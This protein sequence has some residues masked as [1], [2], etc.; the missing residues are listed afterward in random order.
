VL[1]DPPRNR[2]FLSRSRRSARSL[3]IED[4]FA[5]IRAYFLTAVPPITAPIQLV[6]LQVVPFSG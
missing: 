4:G 2:L 6:T 5:L 3:S 1:G